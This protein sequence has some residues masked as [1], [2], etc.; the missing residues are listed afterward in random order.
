MAKGFMYIL[1]CCDNSYYTGSTKDLE[2]RFNQHQAGEGSNYT[3]NRLPVK[4]AYFEEYDRIDFAFNREKQVQKWSRKKK[5]ALISGE[6][7][8]IP[9]LAKKIFKNKE[10]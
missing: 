7:H 6:S 2:F 4:L 1:L 10:K 8:L 3:K 5:E 9:Q